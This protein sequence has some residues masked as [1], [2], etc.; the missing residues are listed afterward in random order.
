MATLALDLVPFFQARKI[1]ADRGR[2]FMLGESGPLCQ[3][4]KSVMEALFTNTR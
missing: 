4:H 1:K 3:E 2:K